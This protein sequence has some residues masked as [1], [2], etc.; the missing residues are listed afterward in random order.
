LSFTFSFRLTFKIEL[1]A[2]TYYY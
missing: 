1:T 2:I